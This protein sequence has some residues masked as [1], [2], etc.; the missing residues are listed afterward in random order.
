MK[1]LKELLVE[2][3]SDYILDREPTQK[4]L[5]EVLLECYDQVWTSDHDRHR[6][7]STFEVVIKINDE[8]VDRYFKGEDIDV[9][10]ECADKYDCGW[11]DDVDN[12]WEVYPVEVIKTV[13]K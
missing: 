12:F 6:R 10:G 2:Y 7:Y 11:V 9:H 13:Y 8:G 4:E 3:T 1:T 5:M